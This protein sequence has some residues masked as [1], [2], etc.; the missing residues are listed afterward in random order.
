MFKSYNLKY[1]CNMFNKLSEGVY[2]EDV[3]KGR[4]GAVLVSSDKESIPI[5]RT[6]SI[7]LKPVQRFLPVHCDIIEDIKKITNI[8][9]NNALIEI[10]DNKYITMGYHSD[11]SLDLE[12]DSYI[13]LFSCYENSVRE[14]NIRTLRIKEKYIDDI[15]DIKLYNNTLI[16]FSTNTNGDYLHKI[17]LDLVYNS[18]NRWL[19]LTF[20]TS[21]TYITFNN[22]I[23]YFSNSG[24]VLILANDVQRKEFYRYRSI[25]NKVKG[26]KY[27]EIDYT[28]SESD[29]LFLIKQ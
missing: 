8:E 27:C 24:K 19:G 2:L 16:V 5:V 28:L 25:E 11:Q 21:K 15:S 29:L 10:Y 22:E 6:T 17:I 7:Y 20:R 13:C 4:K 14:S 26:Y 12:D 9:P 18:D 1:E 23:P 3:C